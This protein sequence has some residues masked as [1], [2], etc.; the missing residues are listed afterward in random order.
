MSEV[1]WYLINKNHESK[2]SFF[3][4]KS[5]QFLAK[6]HCDSCFRDLIPPLWLCCSERLREA[7]KLCVGCKGYPRDWLCVAWRDDAIYIHIP[8][9]SRP[10][11]L[12]FLKRTNALSSIFAAVTENGRISNDVKPKC[13]TKISNQNKAMYLPTCVFRYLLWPFRP[14][15]TEMRLILCKSS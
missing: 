11:S 13:L 12:S 14:L 1:E 7:T 5:D 8:S 9:L 6:H 3:R 10:D 15:S 2:I 4:V